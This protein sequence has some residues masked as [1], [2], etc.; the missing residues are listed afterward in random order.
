MNYMR[1]IF[2]KFKARMIVGMYISCNSI[3]GGVSHCFYQ[4]SQF[5]QN[6]PWGTAGK[7]HEIS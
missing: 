4:S 6:S 2:K 3:T 5:Q 1:I 7:S